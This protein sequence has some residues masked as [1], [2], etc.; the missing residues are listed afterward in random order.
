M[1]FNYIFQSCFHNLSQIENRNK[2]SESLIRVV[3][4]Q[5]LII[6]MRIKLPTIKS[7]DLRFIE[8]GEA[9]RS[10]RIV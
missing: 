10:D 9:P 3:N 1:T 6:S 8:V 2:I 7:L 4:K 5:F